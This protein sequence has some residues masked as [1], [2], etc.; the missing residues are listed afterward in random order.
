MQVKFF[1][2]ASLCCMVEIRL[3]GTLLH[4]CDGWLVNWHLAC[5]YFEYMYLEVLVTGWSFLLL[6]WRYRFRLMMSVIMLLT[7]VLP[8]WH[9]WRCLTHSVC[10]HPTGT[11]WM[12]TAE[13]VCSVAGSDVFIHAPNKEYPYKVWHKLL[14]HG[15]NCFTRI[16]QFLLV[17]FCEA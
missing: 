7:R 15:G 11:M 6:L 3:S 14:H 12:W 1:L 17:P 5:R 2:A 8:S 16:S 4:V 10:G 9:L 13:E